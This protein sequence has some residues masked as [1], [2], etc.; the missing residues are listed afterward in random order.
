MEDQNEIIARIKT[1]P[2]GTQIVYHRGLLAEDKGANEYDKKTY[3]QKGLAFFSGKVYE[4]YLDGFCTLVQKRLDRNVFEYIAI[5]S[6]KDGRIERSIRNR[7]LH[8]G[9]LKG[10]V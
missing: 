9:F 4:A 10:T 5:V 1:A 2:E 7:Q 6:P 8:D 3:M